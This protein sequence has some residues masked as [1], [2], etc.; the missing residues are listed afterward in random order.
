V[1]IVIAIA[2]TAPS[3]AL[4]SGIRRVLI[5]SNLVDYHIPIQ[6][7]HGQEVAWFVLPAGWR[8]HL[9][10]EIIATVPRETLTCGFNLHCAGCLQNGAINLVPEGTS[11]TT[12]VS[13]R[14]TRVFRTALTALTEHRSLARWITH[15]PSA[16]RR[17]ALHS[18]SKLYFSHCKPPGVSERMWSVNLDASISG[19]YQTLGGH[20]CRLSE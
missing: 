13:V 15:Y 8:L 4:H 19:E 7:S 20:S 12:L 6:W 5:I 2:R 18:I 16:R 14:N 1:V 9:Y 17:V 11:V 3:T 10:P